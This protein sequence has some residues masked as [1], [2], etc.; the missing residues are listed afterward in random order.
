MNAFFNDYIFKPIQDNA[1]L[2]LTL[3]ST[4]GL[5]LIMHF[6]AVHAYTEYCVPFTWVGFFASPF[7]IASPQCK[8]LRWVIGQGGIQIDTMWLLLGTWLTSRFLF[9]RPD[10]R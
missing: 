2:W 10:P 1:I 6:A 9:Q 7:T 4:Y 3:V 8:A 5:W